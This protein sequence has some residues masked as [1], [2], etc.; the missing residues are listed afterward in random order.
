MRKIQLNIVRDKSMTGAGMPYRIYINGKEVTRLTF[1]QSYSTEINDEPTKL[2]VSMVGNAITI[3]KIEK[4]ITLLPNNCKS[5]LINCQI[6]TKSNPL[7]ILSGGL[8]KAAGETE[9][10]VVYY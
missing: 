5:G 3:H 2:K 8:F 4:E 10:N 1:G 7:G 6:T 9:I